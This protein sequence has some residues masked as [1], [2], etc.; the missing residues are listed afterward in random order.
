M[1]SLGF[2]DSENYTYL[3]GSSAATPV[4]SSVIALLLEKNFNL[5]SSEITTILHDS[6]EKIGSEPYINGRNNKYGYGKV[7]LTNA[8]TLVP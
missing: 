7:H 3:A 1:G 6:V 5:T 8:L 4:V 2:S